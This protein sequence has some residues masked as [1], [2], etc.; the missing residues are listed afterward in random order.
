MFVWMAVLQHQ[1]GEKKFGQP[2]YVLL[3]GCLCPLPW[4][5]GGLVMQG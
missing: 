1:Q 5:W 3:G 4:A 2:M